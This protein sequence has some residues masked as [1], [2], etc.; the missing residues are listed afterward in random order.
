MN[1]SGYVQDYIYSIQTY[2]TYQQNTLHQWSSSSK[3]SLTQS[4][5]STVHKKRII[6]NNSNAS[7]MSQKYVVFRFIA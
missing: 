2:I 1:V 5:Q 3:F 6:Y 7:I 4:T